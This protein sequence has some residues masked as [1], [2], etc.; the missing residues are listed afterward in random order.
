MIGGG[1]LLQGGNIGAEQEVGL[2][3]GRALPPEGTA[4]AKARGAW[5]QAWERGVEEMEGERPSGHIVKAVWAAV[6]TSNDF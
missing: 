3:M 6:K 1:G 2:V 4:N 5:G